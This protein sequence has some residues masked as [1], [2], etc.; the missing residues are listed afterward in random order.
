MLIFT[1]RTDIMKVLIQHGADVNALSNGNETAL[2]LAI[3]LGI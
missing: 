3:R 1:D 2:T